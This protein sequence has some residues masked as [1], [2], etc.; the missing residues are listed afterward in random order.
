MMHRRLSHVWHSPF[1]LINV[2]L[3]SCTAIPASL[4][5]DR[6]QFHTSLRTEKQNLNQAAMKTK[7]TIDAVRQRYEELRRQREKDEEELGSEAN[8]EEVY[9]IVFFCCSAE[10]FINFFFCLRCTRRWTSMWNKPIT[11][12]KRKRRCDKI[13]RPGRTEHNLKSCSSSTGS[14]RERPLTATTNLYTCA[15]ALSLLSF[16]LSFFLFL[17]SLHIL[18]FTGA[19]TLWATRTDNWRARPSDR[20][21]A[22]R[23]SSATSNARTLPSD[24]LQTTT[25]MTWWTIERV[26]V[27]TAV[28]RRRRRRRSWWGM[29]FPKVSS[30]NLGGVLY[31]YILLQ[32][33]VVVV[34]DLVNRSFQDGLIPFLSSVSQRDPILAWLTAPW[35]LSVYLSGGGPVEI[36]HI[37]PIARTVAVDVRAEGADPVLWMTLML[38]VFAIIVTI[39][40]AAFRVEL[41]VVDLLQ[42]SLH[43]VSV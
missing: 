31:I 43:L 22:R 4:C 14:S 2:P 19:R 41:V 38:L 34:V 37:A 29:F 24:D 26:C 40:E 3:R 42:I 28:S 20:P 21:P 15:S 32:P 7:Q 8:E 12:L 9:T 6:A 11:N 27:W 1:N 16:F 10:L 23:T 18:P 17:F 25:A 36:A 5:N 35:S 13:L 30:C 33:H 39:I